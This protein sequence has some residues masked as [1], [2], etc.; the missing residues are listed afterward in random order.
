MSAVRPRRGQP[1]SRLTTTAWQASIVNPLRASLIIDAPEGAVRRALGR[2]DTWTRTATALGVRLEV[3]GPATGARAAL[4]SGDLLRIRA[5]GPIARLTKAAHLAPR[6]LIL[7]VESPG[8]ADRDPDL[9]PSVPVGRH[10]PPRPVPSF[11]LVSGPL[12][13]CRIS[14]QTAATA[15]GTVATVECRIVATPELLTPL[16]RRRILHAA[17]MLL[18]IATLVA[19]EP[20]VVVGAAIIVDQKVLAAR[21][22]GPPEVAGLWELPGGKVEPGETDEQAVRRELAEELGIDAVVAGRVGRDIDLG[23]NSVLRCYQVEPAAGR[24]PEPTEHDALRWLDARD[25]DTV[26]WL[27]ADRQVLGDLQRAML[28]WELQRRLGPSG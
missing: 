25:L 1:H 6:S 23:D 10:T 19:R 24:R 7:E 26:D 21:R 16:L 20:V 12:R 13:T 9:D 3:A 22:A 4:R 11:T 8:G 28:G 15:A 14:M 5:D 27:P 18:G 2:T 17:Q